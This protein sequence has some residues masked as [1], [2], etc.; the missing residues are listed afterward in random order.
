M[1]VGVYICNCGGNISDT[2]DVEKVKEAVAKFKGVKAAETYISMCSFPGQEMMKREIKGQGLNRIVVASCSPRMHLDTF[3]RTLE[4]AGLNKYFLDMAN[5]REQCS[6]VH[7][8][9]EAATFKAIDLIRGAVARAHYLEPLETKSIPVNRNVLVIGGGIAGIIASLELAD[10][11]LQVYLVERSP[12]IGG[13]MAQLSK[14]FPTMDCSQCIL[15]PRMVDVAQHPNIKLI[16]LAEVTAVEGSPGNY[17][18]LVTKRSRYVDESKCTGCSK[19]AEVCPVTMPSEYELGLVKRKAIYRLFPQA[20]PPVFAID[21]R[22]IPPCRVACPSGVNV[23]GYAALISQGKFKEALE[24]IRGHIPFPAVCGRVCFVP[25]E[26][27][28]ERGK[29]DEPLSIRALK[30]FVADHESKEGRERP[31]LIPKTHEEK[32]AIIGSGPAGLTAAYDLVKKGYPV[33][34]FESLPRPGGMLRVGIP[35]YRMPK[36]VLDDEIGYIKDLGV[37]I[38]TNLT[39]GKDLTIDELLRNEYKAVFIAIGAQKSRRLGI[40][41]EDLKGVV[42]ALDLLREVN[43]EKKVELGDRVAVIGGGNVAVDAARVAL[44]LGSKEV[45][46]LYRRSRVEMPAFTSEVEEAEKEGIKIRFLASPTKILGRE[47]RVVSLECVRM[48][49]G[50]PD[51]TG[52]RQPI[53][54]EGSEHIIEF[55]TIILALGQSPDISYLPKGIEVTRRNTIV[56]DPVT[57]ETN[58]P[59]I[60][61]GGDAVSGAATVIEAIADG[62]R[63]AVSIDRYL[64]GEDLRVDR[65]EEIK[66]VKEVPKEGIEKKARQTMP[67]LPLDQRT[68]FEEVELG[69]TE[70]MAMDEASRCLSCGGCSEC[71]ECEKVCVS[72]EVILH[73]QKE[74]NMELE[75]G[76]IVACTGFDQLDPNLFEENNYGLH[77]DIVTNLQFEQLMLQGIH[78]PSNGNVPK[79]VAFILC[80]GSRMFHSDKGVKHCCKIGCMAAIKEAMLLQKAV[81]DAEPWIFYTD[82]RTDGKGYEEYYATAQ[83]HDVRFVRG[84]VAEVIPLNGD[85]L[86][87]RAEDTFVGAPI[88]ETFDLVVLSNGIISSS[89]TQ[90]LARKLGIQVGADGFLVEKHYKLK[91]VDTGRRLVFASGCALGPKDVRET[92]LEAMATASRVATLLGKGEITVS[93]EVARIVQEK[94]DDCGTCMEVCPVSAVEK[95]PA[96]MSINSIS[97]IGC[98]ICVPRCSREA[99]ELKHST[100]HQLLAQIRGVAK[101]GRKPKIV[102]FIE[103]EIA[104]GSADLAGQSRASYPPNVDIIRVPT[105]GRVGLKHVLYAFAM[106]ADGVIFVEDHG[107]VFTDEALKEQVREMK[108]ELRRYRVQPLRL[109]SISTTLPQYDKILNVFGT[110]AARL[111]KMGLLPEETRSKLQIR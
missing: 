82:M 54:I 105:T 20:V 5:I 11:G 28:C 48:R 78:K 35:E 42:H 94:C 58:L 60:F 72:K 76:A 1:K 39:I 31:A 47:G 106:G 52:R 75:V 104:Y 90:E 74:E 18:V 91:P 83:D 84:R 98:G 34:V 17:R 88:E 29:V 107:G 73:Q 103:K 30:R 16:T 92:T 23:Q 62:K 66:R 77:P 14:T 3:G 26:N 59:G 56:V 46:I 41:G 40:E 51:E 70:E 44:R 43:L 25:C 22:G 108:K 33:T 96:G 67:L 32:V 81:P 57:L 2:V 64:R 8:D 61:S 68:G 36:S 27:E 86:L 65:E 97:C 100:E 80:V 12:S 111:E 45:T 24:L 93:P 13:H 69:F 38:R 4:S 101:G 7:D 10:K 19:C 89:G 87:V 110:L 9:A 55:D 15:T 37:E 102:A 53:S 95:S 99:I 85:Q 49:L 21:K 79:K 6:W 63:V 50:E 109:L 71:L